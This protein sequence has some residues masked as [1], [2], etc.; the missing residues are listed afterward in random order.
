MLGNGPLSTAPLSASFFTNVINYLTLTAT[1]SETGTIQR[2]AAK[3][4]LP[5]IVASADISKSITKALNATSSAIASKTIT[6]FKDISSGISNTVT[7][8]KNVL[9]TLLSNTAESSTASKAISINRTAN[10]TDIGTIQ[11]LINK[12]LSA[13]TAVTATIA[14]SVV[15]L[16]VS[17]ATISVLGLFSYRFVAWIKYLYKYFVSATGHYADGTTKEVILKQQ[18]EG[19][20][21]GKQTFEGNQPGKQQFIYKKDDKDLN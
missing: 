13:T 4:L 7:M 11:K 3:I 2:A 5:V 17:F 10:I 20:Q 12:S 8:A 9:K 1:S 19:D 14:K 21:P 18:F 16:L 15:K 6:I